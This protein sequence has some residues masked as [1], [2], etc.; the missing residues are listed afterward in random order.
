MTMLII[1]C[2]LIAVG[3]MF[4][5]MIATAVANNAMRKSMSNVFN[6]DVN[7]PFS[8]LFVS[9]IARAVQLIGVAYGAYLILQYIGY[10]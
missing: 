1:K 4:V 6:M 5:N 2:V 9:F 10:V 7:L 3:I 8:V